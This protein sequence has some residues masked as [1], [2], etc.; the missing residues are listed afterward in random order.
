MLDV[1]KSKD[2]MQRE[3]FMFTEDFQVSD[4]WL[5]VYNQPFT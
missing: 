3:T 4:R 5:L 1:G 2:E